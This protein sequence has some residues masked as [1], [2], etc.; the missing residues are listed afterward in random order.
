M[1][2]QENR[3]LLHTLI[4]MVAANAGGGG[5]M[6]GGAGGA[7]G[8]GGEHGGSFAMM[9]GVRGGTPTGSVGSTLGDSTKVQMGG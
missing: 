8:Q 7:G 5:G 2:E 6:L 3:E 1:E 4:R 9:G